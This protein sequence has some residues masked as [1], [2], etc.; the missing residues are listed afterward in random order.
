MWWRAW[1]QPSGAVSTAAGHD[2]GRWSVADA[3]IPSANDKLIA[4]VR[5]LDGT[6][7][8]PFTTMELACLQSLVEPEEYLELDGLSDQGWRERIG[9]AVPPDA[10]RAITE[11]MGTTL[12]LAESGETFMLS[13]TPVWVRPVAV[14]LSVAQTAEAY[15]PTK[16]ATA[17][18]AETIAIPRAHFEM[19]SACRAVST[20]SR[21]APAACS[22]ARSARSSRL[23]ARWLSILSRYARAYSK[24]LSPNVWRS[25]CCRN[26][27][28]LC[29]AIHSS[30]SA[31]VSKFAMVCP[32]SLQRSV[33]REGSKADGDCGVNLFLHAKNYIHRGSA[34]YLGDK[35][36]PATRIRAAVDFDSLAECSNSRR[37]HRALDLEPNIE[38]VLGCAHKV[39][40]NLESSI[41]GNAVHGCLP[42]LPR[43]LA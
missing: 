12:L 17:T 26:S 23:C 38:H 24:R 27:S 40:M 28:S 42:M 36:C 6:W 9:N 19:R 7:H 1:D 37:P 5:A 41:F 11:V 31:S 14:A 13:A 43:I 10:A 8:R 2:N 3:R 33:A 35:I 20:W 39:N 22:V 15:F 32:L 16:P 25:T 4:I 18:N 29:L 30:I 34:C 21:A